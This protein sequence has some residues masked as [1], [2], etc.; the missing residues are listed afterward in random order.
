MA[1][2]IEPS[3]PRFVGGAVLIVWLCL[4]AG[5]FWLFQFKYTNNWVSFMGS[6][7][8]S[9][10]LPTK[11][12][13]VT[14]VHFVDPDCPCS[15]YSAPHIQALEQ[16]W[17]SVDFKTVTEGGSDEMNRMLEA[18]VPASPA[19]A[20]WNSQGELQFFGPYTAGE[21]C[22]EG[23]DLLSKALGSP[24]EGQ[25]LNQEAVGC[26]CPWSVGVKG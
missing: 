25:W 9:V 14:V 8:Q 11:T 17:N 12:G 1:I 15:K 5:L 26:F 6:E 23:E 3:P 18:F 24:G 22:G 10:E 21:F 13:Q 7:F 2:R 19:V 4:M 20:M 16:K